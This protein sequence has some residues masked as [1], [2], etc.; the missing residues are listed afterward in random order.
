MVRTRFK[1]VL[2]VAPDTIPNQLLT[3]YTH[4]KHISATAN[5]FPSI[6]EMNPDI[7]VFDYELMGKE[8]EKTLRRIMVNKF[9]SKIKICCFKNSANEKADSFL[10]AIGVDHFIYR[11]DLTQKSKSKFV[12]NAFNSIVDVSIIKW[13]FNVTH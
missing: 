1:K 7:I 9:Y 4:V 3:D 13:V 2:L 8:L 5:I 12:S 10:K 6:Y 11:E